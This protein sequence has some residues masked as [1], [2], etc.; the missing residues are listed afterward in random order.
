MKLTQLLAL[1]LPFMPFQVVLAQDNTQVTTSPL[2]AADMTTLAQ[3]VRANQPVDEFEP[4]PKEL[5]A[6]RLF[7]VEL[8]VVPCGSDKT[9][10]L[11][12]PLW[13]YDAETETLL[14]TFSGSG[15]ADGSTYRVSVHVSCVEQN[16][17]NYAVENVFGV[18]TNIGKSAQKVVELTLLSAATKYEIGDLITASIKVPPAE[19][20]VLSQN[21]RLR[22]E[23]E[24]RQL[25]SS[26]VIKCGV[27]KTRVDMNTIWDVTTDYC[28]FGAHVISMDYVDGRSGQVVA[29]RQDAIQL[30]IDAG[31]CKLQDGKPLYC[32]N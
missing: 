25:S 17:G 23:G 19:A 2:I 28:R 6:S 9:G 12:K 1:L 32:W 10:C 18:R 29:T 15:Y 14:M 4:L 27:D 22:V 31:K 26:R 7:R 3:T 21:L 16:L 20:R 5:S 24:L 11:G 30:L 8:P 13:S